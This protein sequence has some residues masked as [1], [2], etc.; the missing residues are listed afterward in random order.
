MKKITSLS[1]DTFNDGSTYVSIGIIDANL[2]DT[3]RTINP[4]IA[5]TMVVGTNIIF[6]KNRIKHIQKHI[7]DFNSFQEYKQCFY[8]I[9]KIIEHPDYISTNPKDNSISFIK[10]YTKNISVAVRISN[11]GKASFRTMYP[12]R[13]SQIQNYINNGRAKQINNI[14]LFYIFMYN[15]S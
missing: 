13:D 1:D 11:D 14:W 3:I 6:W 7:S 12:L 9:P 2:I 4:D 15:Q 5:N 10:K 8:D